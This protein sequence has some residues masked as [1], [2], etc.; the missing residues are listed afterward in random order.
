[1]APPLPP[2]PSRL[3][4]T[5]VSY[6]GGFTATE[7][8]S[9]EVIAVI[10]HL[11]GRLHQ[12]LHDDKH[13]EGIIRL[14]L[15]P[16]G[17]PLLKG[18]L[19]DRRHAQNRLPM[20]RQ[21]PAAESQSLS[22]LRS[23]VRKLAALVK[24][25]APIGGPQ[26]GTV[27]TVAPSYARAAAPAATPSAPPAPKAAKAP[28][29]AKTAPADVVVM[30]D[31]NKEPTD[32]LKF[33]PSHH[34]VRSINAGAIERGKATGPIVAAV[35]VSSRHNLVFSPH[36]DAPPNALHELI[37]TISWDSTIPTYRKAASESMTFENTRP[38]YGTVVTAREVRVN[39]PWS[40]LLLHRVPTG[41]TTNHPAFSMEEIDASLREANPRYRSL[42]ITQK[43]SW[44]RHPDSYGPATVSSISFAFEDPDG[45]LANAILAEHRLIVLGIYAPV[46]R[47]KNKPPPPKALKRKSA[48]APAPP[49]APAP[50]PDPSGDWPLPPRPAPDPAVL[51]RLRRAD[52]TPF[53]THPTTDPTS[54]F[55]VPPGALAPVAPPPPTAPSE[56]DTP[57]HPVQYASDARP[58]T[59]QFDLAARIEHMSVSPPAAPRKKAKGRGRA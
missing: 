7:N 3:K 33:F 25:L 13:M 27:P 31:H 14:S 23:E 55:S 56:P 5:Q 16:D 44:V 29:P 35:K 4:T 34:V 19:D 37:S 45:E 20:D 24:N 11:E 46:R 42:K 6:V 49:P 32:W 21:T 40:R 12:I 36:P 17:H 9:N 41:T 50:G 30:L 43:P 2:N 52:P 51:A 15:T 47:W 10:N 26:Q 59:P 58:S 53:P 57:M 22:E 39:T 54:P 28:R 48:A 18:L 8:I 1:M 38:S